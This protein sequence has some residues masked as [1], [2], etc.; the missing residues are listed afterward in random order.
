M[1]AT[2]L[3]DKERAKYYRKEYAISFSIL[4]LVMLVIVLAILLYIAND[5][6]APAKQKY[7]ESTET[8]S[9]QQSQIGDLKTQIS[10]LQSQLDAEKAAYNELSNEKSSVE[11]L[12]QQAYEEGWN[13]ACYEYDLEP[14]SDD[15]PAYDYVAEID[16]DNSPTAYITPSGN[17]YHLSQSC[18][19]ENAIQTTIADASDKGYTPCAKCAQ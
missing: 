4:F 17:R 9:E 14:N 1:K 18:A 10:D 5:E 7:V 2:D 15:I 6:N 8:I 16:K 12:T 13:D 3:L 11:D 19:G